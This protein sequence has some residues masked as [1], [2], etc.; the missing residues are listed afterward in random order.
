L[1]PGE[2]VEF[3]LIP[4]KLPGRQPEAK[5]VRVIDEPAQAA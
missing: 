2:R 3:V 4:S 1:E 5:V